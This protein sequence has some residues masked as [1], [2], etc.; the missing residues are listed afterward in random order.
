MRRGKC[1]KIEFVAKGRLVVRYNIKR[2]TRPD[3]DFHPEV[4]QWERR[5]AGDESRSLHIQ[6]K[7][8]K[9][10]KGGT[11]GEQNDSRTYF[12]TSPDTRRDWVYKSNVDEGPSG[13]NGL[14]GVVKKRPDYPL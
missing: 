9:N 8:L 1:N 4:Q 7:R 10:P 11:V 2:A 13:G 5:T 14:T 3:S 12:G 6:T